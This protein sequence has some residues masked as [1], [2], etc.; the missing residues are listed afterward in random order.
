MNR[1][2]SNKETLI[3]FDIVKSSNGLLTEQQKLK[4]YNKWNTQKLEMHFH[5]LCHDKA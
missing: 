4:K 1:T 3:F 2:I 5:Y